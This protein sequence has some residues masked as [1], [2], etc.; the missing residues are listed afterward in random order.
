MTASYVYLWILRRC[1]D[2]LLYRAPLGNCLFHVQVAGFQPPGIGKEYLTSAFQAFYS[3]AFIYL[4]LLKNICEEV[5][6]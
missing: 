4:K 1:S 6:L 3:K 5:N 2:H